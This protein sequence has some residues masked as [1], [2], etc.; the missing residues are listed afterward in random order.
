MMK[1]K[2]VIFCTAFFFL[3]AC[4]LPS[5]P[6][7][8]DPDEELIAKGKEIFFNETFNGNGRTCGSCH[9]AEN[10]F[11]IDPA[12]IATL[13]DDDPLFVAEFNPDLKENFENTRLIREF[14]LI[15]ENL[16][17]FDDL[18]NKFTLRGVPHT[19]GLRF[20]IDN[21]LGPRTGWSGD[22]SPGDGSLRSFAIGA[23][24]QH[25]TKTLN[26]VAGVDFRL[27][28][29]EELDALEAFQFS[30][31]RQQEITLPLPLKGTVAKRG[32]E[33]F[34]DLTLG[35]CSAC[36]FN[37]GANFNPNI[38]FPRSGNLN[39]NTGVEDL[40]DQ[41]QDLTGELVPPDDGF[42]T[43][44]NGEFNTPSLVESADTGPFFHNNSV[45][46]IEG[47]VA[48]YNGDAFNNSPAG[49][50]IVGATGSGINLDGTQVVEVAA[51]LRAI[52]ALE[53]IR[54]SIEML[55]K[56]ASKNFRTVKEGEE[57]LDLALAETK[58][59]S[60]VL[61]GGGLHPEAVRLLRESKKLIK[62]A[63]RSLFSRGR[64][65]REAIEKQEAARNEIV[66]PS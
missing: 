38:P 11:V 30:L 50:L 57:L 53:N 46:T 35:K 24:I 37:A 55:D 42:G 10:N 27:P 54:Q 47:A 3:A 8:P 21:S 49:Q 39:F 51:F 60:T 19:L 64:H 56:F 40:P 25:F 41:P 26:R 45:E 9:P 33:I 34:N 31:G 2:M 20:T 36:H 6:S 52:N 13:P 32:Q 15:T 48:F 63:R 17:G 4:H 62:K 22:G 7:P 14:G 43:P 23:V 18:A 5:P 29:D 59:S 16:D 1:T 44:G 66:E 65:A 28:T 61:K 12:F 58:D